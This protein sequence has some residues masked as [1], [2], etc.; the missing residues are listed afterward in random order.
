MSLFVPGSIVNTHLLFVSPWSGWTAF[1]DL[2]TCAQILPTGIRTVSC[3][4][5]K[6]HQHAD[7]AWCVC[8]RLIWAHTYTSGGSTYTVFCMVSVSASAM[9]SVVLELELTLALGT[10][11]WLWPLFSVNWSTWYNS[12]VSTHAAA[13]NKKARQRTFSLEAA[14]AAE[15]PCSPVLWIS[16]PARLY[17]HCS[18]NLRLWLQ[19]CPF[20]PDGLVVDR[21]AQST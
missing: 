20:Y 16:S 10:E 9:T 17:R 7:I 15:T 4:V 11:L 13:M 8:L 5:C 21:V 12:E 2:V 18:R 1:Q 3:S 14:V 6:R 19:L